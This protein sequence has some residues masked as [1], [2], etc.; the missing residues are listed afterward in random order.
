V[1][2]DINYRDIKSVALDQ[3]PGIGQVVDRSY[4]FR[5]MRLQF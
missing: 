1:K 3:G 2:V 5:P 4:H